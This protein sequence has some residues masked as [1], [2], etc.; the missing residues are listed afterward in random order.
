MMATQRVLV[1]SAATG[2]LR[3]TVVLPLESTVADLIKELETDPPS[4]IS[5]LHEDRAMKAQE[6]LPH[7]D[8]IS[9]QAFA[10]KRHWP[11]DATCGNQ[12]KKTVGPGDGGD[13]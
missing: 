5:I 2:E 12:T 13:L 8:E 10:S 4:A 1:H 3:S 11:L 6:K 9:V 7:G